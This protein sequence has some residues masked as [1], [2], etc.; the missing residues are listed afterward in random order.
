MNALL[1]FHEDLQRFFKDPNQRTLILRG[2]AIEKGMALKL[3]Q[4]IGGQEDTLMLIMALHPFGDGQSWVDGL[5]EQIRSQIEAANQL[6]RSHALEPWPDFPT[7]CLDPSV[8]AE[9]RFTAVLRHCVDYYSDQD[10]AWALLPSECSD[11]TAYACVVRQLLDVEPWMAGQKFVLWDEPETPCLELTEEQATLPETLVWDLDFGPG[12]ALEQW[13]SDALDP[14]TTDE[15]RANLV[16]MLAATDLGYDRLEEA[17]KK[18]HFLL[19]FDEGKH[20]KRQVM[21]LGLMGDVA[22]RQDQ[23]ELALTRYRNGI[24][25]I[26]DQDAP[27]PIMCLPVL[28][29]AS[30]ACVALGDLDEALGYAT[31]AK[32][33][34]AKAVNVTG[35]VEALEARAEVLRAIAQRDTRS[36]PV[37]EARHELLIAQGLSAKFGLETQWNQVLEKE[38]ALLTETQHVQGHEAALADAEQRM[39]GGF[40]NASIPPDDPSLAGADDQRTPNAG[41]PA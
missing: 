2:N 1:R 24:E 3:F 36:E 5:V 23:A 17:N 37:L 34:A 28:S 29:G 19:A 26:L 15:E 10:V 4:A 33:F 9:Q 35:L 32:R 14:R 31:F 27:E 8:V 20:P 11:H 6:R 13:V 25:K 7:D 39:Q 38:I 16:L 21:A 18:L 22:M 40:S 30:K 41:S 12:S